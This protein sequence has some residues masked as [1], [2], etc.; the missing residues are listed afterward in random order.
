MEIERDKLKRTIFGNYK[1]VEVDELLR[2]ADKR[3]QQQEADAAQSRARAAEIERLSAELEE[4]RQTAEGLQAENSRLQER[5]RKLC[6]ECRSRE[7]ESHRLRGEMEELC[8][9]ME[10][11][12]T[13]NELAGSQT[14]ILSR[15][16]A[17]QRQELDEKDKLLL[18]DPVSEASKRAE[19]IIQSATKISKQMLDEAETMRSRAL[20][21][22]RAAFFNTMNFR[23]TLEERF[24]TLQNELDMSMRTLRAIEVE[25][26][27]NIPDYVQEKE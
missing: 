23:Q 7:E 21:A 3:L 22:V 8:V 27:S 6:E 5:N 10:E 19:Q 18:A 17:R 20:A 1:P 14:A 24:I 13:E 15:R 4:L 11:L 25:D 26:E 2:Q 16:V 9:K 12:R